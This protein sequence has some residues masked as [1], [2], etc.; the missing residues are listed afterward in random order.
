[1]AEYVCMICGYVYDEALGRPE[2]GIAP[3]TSWQSLPDDWVCPICGATK[4]EFEKQGEVAVSS[5]RKPEPVAKMSADIARG[6]P[7][8]L[9]QCGR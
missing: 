4:A 3:G 7:R 6:R 2:D 1:M 9:R 5:E 8:Q